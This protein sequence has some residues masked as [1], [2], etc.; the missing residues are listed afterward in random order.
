MTHRLNRALL[1]FQR[2]G[3]LTD[4]SL[5]LSR[6]K[7]APHFASELIQSSELQVFNGIVNPGVAVS[8][9]WPIRLTGRQL[10][11]SHTQMQRLWPAIVTWIKQAGTFSD[12]LML[13]AIAAAAC[14]PALGQQQYLGHREIRHVE[15]I[16][17]MAESGDYVIP[18]LLG[19]V[20][21]D[22][23]PVMHAIA[24][25]LTRW[26]G[27]P[28]LFLAR[29]PSALAAIGVILATYGLG[30]TMKDRWTGILA[31]LVLL[32]IPGLSSMAR[33]ARPDM[34]LCLA[35][36]ACCLGLALGMRETRPGMRTLWF[37][38][39]GVAGG[40]GVVTKGP[41]GLLF[42]VV[43]AI[44]GP[45]RKTG[46][47]R[48][49]AGWLAFAL[50]LLGTGLIWAVPAYLQDGGHYLHDVIFQPDL[51]VT[52]RA[53]PWYNLI[54]PAIF[55]SLPVGL[56]L[57][58]AIRD[59]RREGYSW[60]LACAAAIFL[61]VQLV[62]KKRA[63]YLLPMYPFLGLALT[64]TILRHAASS[65][66]IRQM[67]I[68]VVSFGIVMMPL[69]FGVILRW[70]EDAEDP[71]LRTSRQ[72]LARVDQGHL[73]Y[74]RVGLDEPIAWVGGN[75]QR[76]VTLDFNNPE[77]NEQLKEAPNGSYLVVTKDQQ[78]RLSKT[79]PDLPLETVAAVEWPGRKLDDLLH[80][81]KN[82]SR[83]VMILRLG[84]HQE[85]NTFLD[86]TSHLYLSP[87]RGTIS[88]LSAKHPGAPA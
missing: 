69:F 5:A 29:L 14:L 57:P 38:V 78:E 17:E 53:S 7:S 35:I 47:R 64:S 67:A 55:L 10:F 86:I 72:I 25:K 68:A 50:M 34:I 1:G 44:L 62:P 41:Y 6:L 73:L 37:A 66:R 70:T 21:H 61:I 59:W 75:H 80:P 46:W 31:A 33:Q 13:A 58:L 79:N 63:H 77:I 65:K 51:D 81:S 71:D 42:P 83:Q 32:S 76:I 82:A 48:P 88:H 36:T 28:S 45:I 23:P 74:V 84:S 15:I 43:F 2:I 40:V 24:A 54:A 26:W 49:R 9:G 52:E 3:M 19:R 85:N 22:K 18:H 4:H 20:Y 27:S 30:R 56:F 8:V 87:S 11:P 12:V 39:A 16:R 60:P